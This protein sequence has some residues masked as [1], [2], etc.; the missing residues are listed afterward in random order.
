[1][2]TQHR[3]STFHWCQACA[4]WLYTSLAY[5]VC[6]CSGRLYN[7]YS[8]WTVGCRP[9][10]TRKN[11][12]QNKKIWMRDWSLSP[13]SL[14]ISGACSCHWDTCPGKDECFFEATESWGTDLHLALPIRSYRKNFLVP[15]ISDI[16]E[17]FNNVISE[18]LNKLFDVAI[19]FLLIYH[20]KH[21]NSI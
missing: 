16:A 9:C 3:E 4:V 1:M 21:Y 17:D 13:N 14:S 15:Y 6:P 7:V 18:I 20:G 19:R 5:A 2:K 8:C 11:T 10:N 12:M